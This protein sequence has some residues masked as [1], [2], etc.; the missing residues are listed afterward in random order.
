MKTICH[1]VLFVLLPVFSTA[2]QF[3]KDH[4]R[5][6]VIKGTSDVRI[7]KGSCYEG[8][9]T[10]PETVIE[11]GKEYQV[12]WIGYQAFYRCMTLTAVSIPKSIVS[13][14]N[15]SFKNCE[16]L[17]SVAISE[18]VRHIGEHCFSYCQQLA[19][20][21][22]PS[23]LDTMRYYAFAYCDNLTSITLPPHLNA[24]D[25]STFNECRHLSTVYISPGIRTIPSSTFQNCTGLTSLYLPEGLMVIGSDAFNGC[26]G[27][28]SVKFPQ[29]MSIIDGEAFMNCSSL[30]ADPF[31]NGNISIG[32]DAFKG[33]PNEREILKRQSERYAVIDHIRYETGGG[34][35]RIVANPD[36][37]FTGKLVIPEE[38]EINGKKHRV[39]EIGKNA[40]KK[41]KGLTEVVFPNSIVRM[42]DYAFMYCNALTVTLP[43]KCNYMI[44]VFSNDTLTLTN[45]PA[46]LVENYEIALDGCI[47]KEIQHYPEN[48]ALKAQ[49]AWEKVKKIDKILNYSQF[50]KKYP[51]RSLTE[52]ATAR[53]EWQETHPA[54][55]ALEYPKKVK[56]VNGKYSWETVIKETGGHA[57]FKVESS[58]VTIRDIY[59]KEWGSGHYVSGRW[60][61][62]N[63]S[64]VKVDKG[65]SYTHSHWIKEGD[66]TFTSYRVTWS[67]VDDWGNRVSIIQEIYFEK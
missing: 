33:C 5:Y 58:N 48:F 31:L 17:K 64:T 20:V 47:I 49:E 27:L 42:G 11:K 15:Q 59:K 56:K 18:G 57:G 53:M 32:Q 45:L 23:S 22:L 14:G 40:F 16:Q 65:G 66:N 60:Y 24:W 13:I 1:I 52:L 62:T 54:V 34:L 4:I 8:K 41:N 35:A 12:K 6:E 36:H 3:V 30:L 25:H 44:G 43:E 10:I 9:L 28:T 37:Q 2:Q 21:D 67:G 29:S 61:E 46:S 38:I 19:Q 55:I 7:V 63:Q 26:I 39:T 50:I 51:I